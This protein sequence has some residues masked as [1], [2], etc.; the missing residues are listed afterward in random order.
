[1]NEGNLACARGFISCI[2]VT[3]TL[4]HMPEDAKHG[5]GCAYQT[6][7]STPVSAQRGRD[8]YHAEGTER[9]RPGDPLTK[10][11]TIWLAND[12]HAEEAETFEFVISHPSG[13]A[14]LADA[15]GK[16]T[17]VGDD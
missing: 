7:E 10:K 5:V 11:I 4:S 15:V 12:K 16:G 1:M 17:V 9:F 8:Y 3:V 2:T 14:S 6:R 13:G